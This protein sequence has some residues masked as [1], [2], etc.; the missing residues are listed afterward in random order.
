MVIGERS[1]KIDLVYKEINLPKDIAT[2][3]IEAYET[4]WIGIRRS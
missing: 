4:T 1:Q 3:S 2:K